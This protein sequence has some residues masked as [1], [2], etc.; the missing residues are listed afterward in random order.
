ML[1]TEFW[2]GFCILWLVMISWKRWKFPPLNNIYSCWPYQDV[3]CILLGQVT[4]VIPTPSCY[5]CSNILK[6][7]KTSAL[8]PYIYSCCSY[9]LS[10]GH[11][12]MPCTPPPHFII[13]Q[14]SW[15]RLRSRN[16]I[17][18]CCSCE[19]SWSI[20]LDKCPGIILHSYISSLIK[21]LENGWNPHP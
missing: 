11:V 20:T 9:P 3:L 21:Y 6:T 19:D 17:H 15:K 16:H 7:V 2:K 8:R 10:V 18:S 5:K 14:I 13:F 1:K 4:R 12:S